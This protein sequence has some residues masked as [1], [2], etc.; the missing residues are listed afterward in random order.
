[1]AAGPGVRQ[2]A[3]E[4]PAT[5]AVFAERRLDRQ[6]P[7]QQ[8]RGVTDTDRQ[9]PHR[10]HQQRADMRGEGQIE[11]MI[12]MLAQPVGAEHE[13]AG[14]EGALMQALDGLRVVDG[15]GRDCDG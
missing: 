2:R 4:Q 12:D 6:R 15:F 1:M 7:Q 9:L 11:Q 13:A 14:A 3:V 8:R 10:S 5:D